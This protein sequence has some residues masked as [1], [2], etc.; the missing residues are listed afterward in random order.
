MAC[1]SS[2]GRFTH[3]NASDDAST[4]SLNASPSS[5][6]ASLSLNALDQ[7]P[8]VLEWLQGRVDQIDGSPIDGQIEFAFD[9]SSASNALDLDPEVFAW[10]NE[11]QTLLPGVEP[12][13]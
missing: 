1:L 6:N 8:E 10:L 9:Y 11:P 13:T 7:D 12:I 3:R 4:P 5:V 2:P